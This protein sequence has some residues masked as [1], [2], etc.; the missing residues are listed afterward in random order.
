[1]C[2]FCHSLSGKRVKFVKKTTAYT[3]KRQEKGKITAK[4]EEK[5]ATDN[6][7]GWKITNSQL[8]FLSAAKAI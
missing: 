4:E 2:F 8:Y 3:D 6:F 7:C 5:L 1:M